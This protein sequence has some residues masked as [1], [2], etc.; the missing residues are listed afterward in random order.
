MFSLQYRHFRNLCLRFWLWICN[1]M[2][3]D[4]MQHP[5]WYH[6]VWLRNSANQAILKTHY[7]PPSS[8]RLPGLSFT[9]HTF[10]TV[11]WAMLRS[12]SWKERFL[13]ECR[14]WHLKSE[15]LELKGREREEGVQRVSRHKKMSKWNGETKQSKQK[16]RAESRE[17]N[18]SVAF[19]AATP[20]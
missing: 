15:Q 17:V 8:F 10:A 12:V 16:G 20:Y 6:G 4:V 7:L 9:F 1:W 14:G 5:Q 3:E 13:R 2:F 18:I 19:P 11:S